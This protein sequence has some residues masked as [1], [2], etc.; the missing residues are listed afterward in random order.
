MYHHVELISPVAS[1]IVPAHMFFL[2]D[3]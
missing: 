3:V 2:N 1:E